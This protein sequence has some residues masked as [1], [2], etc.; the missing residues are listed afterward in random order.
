VRV[1]AAFISLLLLQAVPVLPPS[2]DQTL[3]VL[4][5]YLDSLRQQAR[6]PGLAA[7]IVDESG[8][9]W[10]QTF[11]DQDLAADV[12][13]R[14]DTP[15]HL[16][17]LAQIATAT[18]V[19]QCADQ[20]RVTLDG[21]IRAV[22]PKG[23]YGNFTIAQVLTHTSGS[24]DNLV[25]SYD[26]ARLDALRYVVQTCKA[27]TFRW[28]LA[29]QLARVAMMESV[30]GPDAASPELPTLERASPEQADRYRRVLTRLATPYATDSGVV[31]RSQ[32]PN[33][34]L[35]AASGLISTVLDFAKF[36][37]A[38]R[39]GLLLRPTTLASAWR[40]PLNA[41]GQPL[42]HGMGWFVQ[43]YRNEPVVWQV[44]VSPNA[45]SS[46]VITLPSRNVTFV[47]AANSDGLAQPAALTAGNVTVSPFGRV[48]LGLIVK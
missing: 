23:P 21:F 16:D 28:A 14:A 26:V 2:R 22:S 13:T 34:T 30:P 39:Q 8:V 42:P 20:G 19:L 48:F 17:A 3:A 40:A 7:A 9:L 43:T 15:F 1:L 12:P 31:V 18:M 27:T 11:G 45:S 5:A 4:G 33:V 10:T 24:P 47:L 6:I 38:L 25:F 41:S 37:L 32:Y 35:G 29:E 46:L 36:D 44:G